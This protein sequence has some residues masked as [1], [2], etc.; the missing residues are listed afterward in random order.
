M[1]RKSILE[2]VKEKEETKPKIKEI[3]KK[4]KTKE[5]EE[6][7]RRRIIAIILVLLI[8]IGFNVGEMLSRIPSRPKIKSRSNEWGTSNIVEIDKDSKAKNGIRYYLYC[9][10]KDRSGKDCVWK[11]T[12][13]KN[14]EIT[15]DGEYYVFFKG[16]SKDGT[17]GRISEPTH[18]RIDRTS[19]EIIKAEATST[20]S[21]IKVKVEAK[22]LG[23]GIDKY[24]YKLENGEWIES[25]KLN[26][27]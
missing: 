25:E 27:L 19:P 13:T 11:K 12:K 9:V 26:L 10:S 20:Y 3:N 17:V 6:K 14:I 24:Y 21:E 23:S 5:E 8:L 4:E 16:V 7:K 22:D 2:K 18:V 1:K 15:E